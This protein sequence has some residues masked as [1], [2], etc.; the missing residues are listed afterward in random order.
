MGIFSRMGE[1]INANISSMLERAEDPEKM[2]RLMIY[3]ME[4]TLTEI[5]SS[6]AEEIAERIRVER[7]VRDL[8][9]TAGEWESRAELALTKGRED[10]AREALERKLYHQQEAER[11]RGHLTD[12][13]TRVKQYQD[14]IA[15]L[16]EKLQHAH[17]RQKEMVEKMKHARTRQKVEERIYR[18]GTADA[19]TRFEAFN[20][21]LDRI[22]AE[23]E[24]DARTNDQ[25]AERFRELESQTDV[26]AELQRLKKKKTS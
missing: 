2:I 1:I 15:R 9:K 6:A 14:D 22:E 20:E 5:K 7:H 26:E 25:L 11:T 12:V 24:I 17:R 13:D 16:E 18:A 19:F 21:R 3:E 4:D 10:L 23:T 8:E